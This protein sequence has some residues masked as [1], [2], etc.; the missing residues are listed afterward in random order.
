[1]GVA[2]IRDSRLVGGFSLSGLSEAYTAG[3][4]VSNGGRVAV[5]LALVSMLPLSPVLSSALTTTLSP[6]FMPLTLN[7]R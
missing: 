5:Q 7:A 1:M 2:G 4:G 6:V 3:R